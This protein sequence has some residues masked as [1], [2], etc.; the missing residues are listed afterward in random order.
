MKK[1][2]TLVVLICLPLLAQSNITVYSGMTT[3]NLLSFPLLP[4]IAYYNGVNLGISSNIK[5]I[6]L[7]NAAPS[8]EYSTFKFKDLEPG[9]ILQSFGNSY[10]SSYEENL[11]TYKLTLDLKL[12]ASDNRPFRFF[13]HTGVSYIIED[14]PDVTTV[15]KNE[16]GTVSTEKAKLGKLYHF[17]HDLGIGFIVAIKENIGLSFGTQFYSNYKDLFRY[18]LNGGIV[19]NFPN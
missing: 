9:I 18:V 17:A 3:D 15:W 13:A 7:L 14:Y 16:N 1:I 8:I 11:K 19:Y 4:T 6:G 2:F 5:I 12:I 10:V